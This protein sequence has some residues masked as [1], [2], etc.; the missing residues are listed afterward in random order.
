DQ[1]VSLRKS[2]GQEA[3]LK[4]VLT[5]RGKETM[6]KLRAV[7]QELR[8]AEEDALTQRTDDTASTIRA[9]R[10]SLGIGVPLGVLVVALG[11]VLLTRSATRP[12]S[13]AITQLTAT[14]SQLQATTTQQAAGAQEQAAA[15]T[16]TVATV[17]EVTR[18]SEQASERA[19]EM[20]DAGQRNLEIARVGRKTTEDSIAALG[21]VQTQVEAT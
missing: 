14:G 12:V 20:G 8:E 17:D 19:R 4:V 9:A 6:E 5:D 2:K 18:T 21:K 15:V 16:Q 10:Y 7:A 1:T 11:A 13:A 3:A